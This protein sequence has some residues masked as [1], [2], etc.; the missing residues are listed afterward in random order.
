MAKRQSGINKELYL[1]YYSDK[2]T[3]LEISELMR[4]PHRT[5][6]NFRKNILKIPLVQDTIELNSDEIEVLV[7]TLLGDSYIGYV[8]SQSRTPNL[9]FSHSIKQEEY[10]FTKYNA[11][12]KIMSSNLQ[13][14]YNEIGVI[15]GKKCNLSPVNYAI[16]K[17]LNCLTEY[18]N[19]FY[20]NGI[21]IIPVEYIKDKFTAKS[22]AYLFMD[23]GFKNNKTIGL[24]IPCF[25]YDNLKEFVDFLYNKFNI[26]FI[27][28]KDK[29]LYL[30]YKSREIFYNLVSEYITSDSVYKIKH[31]KNI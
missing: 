13:R 26:E 19:A 24:S 12:N 3:D 17:C 9:T 6:S 31:L 5:I 1:K 25:E 4:V 18:R 23:D 20:F 28:K 21:K 10:F 2:K 16:G 8:H 11:L 27:I 29:S 22:L 14:Q 30:R 15:K 7:G